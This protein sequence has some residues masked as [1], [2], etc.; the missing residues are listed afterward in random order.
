[1]AAVDDATGKLLEAFFL[2]MEC[3]HAYQVGQALK[4]LGVTPIFANSPQAKGRIERSFGVLQD[5]LVAEMEL[6]GIKNIPDANSFLHDFFIND[7][8][9]R[10]AAAPE[11]TQPAWRKLP[12]GLDLLTVLSFRYQATVANDN[13][14]RL[15][16][17]T[18]DIP[19]DRPAEPTPKPK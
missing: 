8:N 17:L 12:P 7:Y 2:A 13:A 1:M 4:E 6:R 18:I 14:L 15:G 11:T 19:Q 16:G 10:F 3:S 9:R 5:R